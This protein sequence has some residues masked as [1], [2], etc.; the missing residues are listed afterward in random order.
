MTWTRGIPFEG[1]AFL[2]TLVRYAKDINI[3]INTWIVDNAEG[4]GG[5]EME[6]FLLQTVL[7]WGI[8]E[9][10]GEFIE[11]RGGGM[12]KLTANALPARGAERGGRERQTDRQEEGRERRVMLLQTQWPSRQTR[13]AVDNGIEFS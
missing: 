11:L 5:R 2:S 1:G 12:A 7:L 8:F 9:H 3:R 6:T 4:W 13:S 10:P